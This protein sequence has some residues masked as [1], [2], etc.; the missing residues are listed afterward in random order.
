MFS[1]G[2]S[3]FSLGGSKVFTVTVS[4]Y[5]VAVLSGLL[6]LCAVTEHILVTLG[7]TEGYEVQEQESVWFY[8]FYVSL[9]C[10]VYEDK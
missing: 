5:S 7:V 1:L 8:D 2:G 4:F 10:L 3:K 9:R 6:G